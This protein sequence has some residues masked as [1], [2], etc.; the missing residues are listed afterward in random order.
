MN[1]QNAK[2]L[3]N[4]SF[5][6]E[7][8]L[9][10]IYAAFEDETVAF[11]GNNERTSNPD[12]WS[13]SDAWK[14]VCTVHEEIATSNSD[15]KH[16]EACN[17]CTALVSRLRKVK[18]TPR[19][20]PVVSR[21]KGLFS[22]EFRVEVPALAAADELFLSE[23]RKVGTFNFK[24]TSLRNDL[25]VEMREGSG[26]LTESIFNPPEGTNVPDYGVLVRLEASEGYR[27]AFLFANASGVFTEL[28]SVDIMD[29]ITVKLTEVY[30]D[31]ITPE[32]SIALDYSRGHLRDPRW[33]R[34]YDEWLISRGHE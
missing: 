12:C 9:T 6:E 3:R 17:R 4:E 8:I 30:R 31:D 10:L 11:G 21:S 13:V 24:R 5:S 15:G 29:V 16:L 26:D 20:S 23:V 25:V 1:N 22:D 18:E 28:Y 32:I 14:Y 33:R 34:F 7:D 19:C 27:Q 2:S